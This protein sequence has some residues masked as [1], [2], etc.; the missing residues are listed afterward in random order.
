M[1]HLESNGRLLGPNEAIK[2]VSAMQVQA[3]LGLE[4]GCRQ[5]PHS[6]CKPASAAHELKCTRSVVRQA[7]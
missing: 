2:E 3:A 1:G 5:Y 7:E 6:P 4:E